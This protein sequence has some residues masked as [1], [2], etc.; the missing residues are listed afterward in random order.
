M[1]PVLLVHGKS[2]LHPVVLEFCVGHL[3]TSRQGSAILCHVAGWNEGPTTP[4]W[5]RA[6]S[7]L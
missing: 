7:I 1:V 2:L 3:P 5:L 6:M 4:A